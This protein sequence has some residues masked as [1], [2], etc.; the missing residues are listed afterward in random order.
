MVGAST[1][2]PGEIYPACRTGSGVLLSS[3]LHV[4]FMSGH[5]FVIQNQFL[6]ISLHLSPYSVTLLTENQ[7]QTNQ[8]YVLFYQRSNSTAISRK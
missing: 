5:H 6:I 2:T 7:L 8:A 4:S 1:T 3:A